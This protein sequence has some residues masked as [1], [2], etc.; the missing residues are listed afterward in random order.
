[1]KVGF[2]YNP[3]SGFGKIN[4]SVNWIKETFINEGH[5]IELFQTQKAEDAMN[6]AIK[7]KNYDMLLVAGGDGTLN[8][9]IRGLMSVSKRP[10]IGYIPT[11]TVNDVGHLLGISRNIKRAVKLI[12]KNGIIK[13]IDVSKINDRY[14]IYAAAT[15]KF[16]K[17]SYVTER[18]LKK[19][20]GALAYLFRGS[21]DIFKDYQIPVKVTYDGGSFINTCALV[22]VLNGYRVGGFRLARM[23]AKFDD[24][25]LEARFFKREPGMLFRLFGFFISGGLYNTEKNKTFKSSFYEIETSDHIEWNT[26][27][28]L[29]TKGSIRIDVI[30]RAIK[31]IVHPKKEKRYFIHQNL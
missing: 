8:E 26:D 3:E 21:K 31:M 20:F 10:V 25:I 5:E 1:M 11:G 6:Y 23:K 22:L 9:V 29:A 2:I 27:G 19:K 28:E 4:A 14:F 12:L 7:L 17:V 18:K 15:G 30:P 16:A 13:S 24:G